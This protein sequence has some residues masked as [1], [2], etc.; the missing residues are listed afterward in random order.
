MGNQY[1]IVIEVGMK[2]VFHALRIDSE[3]GIRGKPA[4]IYR[5]HISVLD[6]V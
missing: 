1:L 5:K 6:F 4:T 3:N 2:E